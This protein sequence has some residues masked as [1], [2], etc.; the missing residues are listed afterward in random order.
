MM[1]AMSRWSQS[2]VSRAAPALALAAGLWSAAA[3]AADAPAA[4]VGSWRG[5]VDAGSANSS[6]AQV[7]LSV[8][9]QDGG[10]L[11]SGVLP[12]SHRVEASFVP[13]Q[14]PGVFRPAS[15]G[16]MSVFGG[17]GVGD[18]LNGKPLLWARSQGPR[19]VVYM[20]AVGDNGGYAL[21]R[22]AC[23]RDGQG[24]TID[25]VRRQNGADVETMTAKL[26]PASNP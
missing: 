20:L 21:D 19:L 1:V 4:L 10:F 6:G 9:Q 12:G 3:L 2:V 23:T 16:I 8:T 14:N 5:S 17:D 26:A 11:L 13:A 22:Y 25:F 24:V 7:T 18:P 15:G